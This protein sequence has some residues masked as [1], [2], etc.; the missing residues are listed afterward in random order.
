[1]LYTHQQITRSSFLFL[2]CLL[3]IFIN[4][5][6]AFNTVNLFS[7]TCFFSSCFPVPT[8]PQNLVMTGEY[9]NVTI[10]WK[11][12]GSIPITGYQVEL[13][14]SDFEEPLTYQIVTKTSYHVNIAKACF[15]K[16]F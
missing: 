14:K 2:K 12:N 13:Q 5:T 10:E 9:P 3:Q 6:K 11:R 16:S 8:S 15:F 7:R 4:L 1:M